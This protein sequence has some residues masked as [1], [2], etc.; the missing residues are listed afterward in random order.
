MESYSSNSQLQ[1]LE[2]G[3]ALP[4]IVTPPPGPQ[5]RELTRAS[6]QGGAS[7]ELGNPA[8]ADARGSGSAHG[9]PISLDATTTSMSI[10]RQ[11]SAWLLPVIATRVSCRR[12]PSSR[13][14]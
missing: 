3:T 2:D 8:R 12:L 1:A 9:G 4:S 5:S 11:D 6:W 14:R 7:Y 10:L 13:K